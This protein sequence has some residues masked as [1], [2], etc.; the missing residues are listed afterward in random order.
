MEKHYAKVAPH[1]LDLPEP[2]Q[3][4]QEALFSLDE[5]T[6]LKLD[7]NEATVSPSPGVIK[8]LVRTLES[9]SLNRQADWRARAL[10]RKLALYTGSNFDS[11]SCFANSITALEAIAR[12]YLHAGV[13]AAAAWPAQT[14][15]ARCA[16]GTEAKIKSIRMADPYEWNLEEITS[17]ITPR[18]RL[19]YFANPNE[20]TG[21]H[22]TEAEL[23]FLLSYAENAMVV[24]DEPYFE[25]CGI[26]MADLVPRFLNL[27]VIRSFS[28]A[29]A[30]A[31][32][33]SA[34]LLTDPGNL[35]FIN[36]IAMGKE[37]GALAQ[38][39]AQA[40]LED[41]GYTAAYVQQIHESKKMLFETLPRLGY[42]FRITLAN[43]FV[44]RVQNPDRL[45]ST[46]AK[47]NIFIKS[48]SDIERFENHVRI[49]IGTPSQTGIL[50]DILGRVAESQVIAPVE[51]GAEPVYNRLKAIDRE[52]AGLAPEREAATRAS[53]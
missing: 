25:F 12:T 50:L 19:I 14:L 34:Y 51:Y 43:Y 47:N 10:R 26:T 29:F 48:L 6:L 42:D 52:V 53:K 45:L 22:L 39:A 35:K 40:A 8:T 9:G 15:I 18:T 37:P 3:D 20:I 13:E 24:I 36:R 5:D 38:I 1:V 21:A 7:R 44:L 16:A 23:V 4:L 17:A 32:I 28:K 49:T 11:I 30:M 33:N 41:T 46:L 27:A 2:E 31:G